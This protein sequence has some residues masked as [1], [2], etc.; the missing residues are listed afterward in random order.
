M[1]GTQVEAVNKIVYLDQ[2]NPKPQNG[3]VVVKV[4][5]TGV[6]GSDVPRVLKGTVHS[7]PQTLGH[8]A[9]GTVCEVGAGVDAALIGTRVSILPLVPCRACDECRAGHFS[10]CKD[11]SFIGSRRPG[12]MAEYVAVPVQNIFPLGDDVS[13]LEAA[14]FE[15]ASIGIHGIELARFTAGSNAIVI[16]AGTIGI[17]TA[18]ELVGYGASRV[19]VSNH[20]TA[21]LKQAATV[22]LNRLVD[23]S[24]EGWQEKAFGLNDGR[25]FDYV[26]DTAGTPS[27]IIDSL[28]VA[29]NRATVCFIGTPKAPVSFSVP[30]WELINRKEL[31]V[32]GAWMSYSHPW[33]GIEW[34]K[35]NE[36]FGRGIMRVDPSMIDRIYN[37]ADIA[38]AFKTFEPPHK[39]KGKIIIDSWQQS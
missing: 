1:K 36:F 15:P 28:A 33:P 22:G 20:S 11:Y 17:L 30:Q 12:T 5:Y 32:T 6:C 16:G 25:A 2:P 14:F 10:L 3:E 24:E 21:R 19:V 27:T 8:E 31:T 18:Q 26:F 35:V 37:L 7:F 38:E 29:A 34:A 23:T 9:S 39:A 4:H 13:D